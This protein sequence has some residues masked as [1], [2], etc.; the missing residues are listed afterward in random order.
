MID[1]KVWGEYVLKKLYV[2]LCPY[3]KHPYLKY[4]LQ[5]YNLHLK[6][7]EKYYKNEH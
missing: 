7:L 2:H 3:N 5:I 1:L 6:I 4:C